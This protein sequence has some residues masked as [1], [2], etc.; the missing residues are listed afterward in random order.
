MRRR[1]KDR[2]VMNFSRRSFPPGA[3]CLLP[4]VFCLLLTVLSV[5]ITPAQSTPSPRPTQT[6]DFQSVIARQ[7]ALVSEFDVNGL[8]VLVTRRE[9]SQ[10][11]A[12]GL[13][14]KGGSRNITASN[15]GI[16]TL[17]LDVMTQGS[18][19]Y[20][21]ERLRAELARTGTVI[22]SS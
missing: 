4:T 14:V 1:R 13:F 18:A 5:P 16:E 20:P 12:A 8:K 21:R 10:T 11:V 3:Y 7:A 9:G 19:G 17:M 15:A 6:P 22:G 2:R